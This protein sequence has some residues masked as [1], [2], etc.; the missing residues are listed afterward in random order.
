M[1]NSGD[2]DVESNFGIIQTG[3]QN[4]AGL[5]AQSVSGGG[6][7]TGITEGS[8]ISLGANLKK[9]SSTN[10]GNVAVSNSS[11]ILTSGVNSAGLIAQSIGGGGG[12]SSAS[13][14]INIMIGSIAGAK[15]R[16]IQ[17]NSG[18]ASLANTGD[19]STFED[20]SAALL[21]QSVGGGG[22]YISQTNKGSEYAYHL[23]Q[24]NSQTISGCCC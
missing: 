1:A 6:G 11:S 12:V 19:I 21:I 5:I 18:A 22:G 4:S 16:N 24:A 20:G 8:N 14:G 9:N 13:D 2:I 17:A 15:A 3:G 7:Y 10:S 23:V